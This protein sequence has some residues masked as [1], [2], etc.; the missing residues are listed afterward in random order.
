MKIDTRYGFVVTY[1]KSSD[2]GEKLLID[3]IKTL[4]KQNYYLILASHSADVPLEVQQLC[5]FYFYQEL[6]IVDDRKYSHGVAE[7]NLIEIALQHLK[8]KKIEWTY[9]VCYDVVIEDVSRFDDWIQDYNYS[10]VSCNWGHNF[11][12]T[13]SFFA[14]VNFILNNIDFYDS[15]EEM[16][17]ID[18]VLEN[19]WQ[20]NIEDKKLKHEVYSYADKQTFFSEYNKLD[21][22]AY[23]Y[24]D[25]TFTVDLEDKKFYITNSGPDFIGEFRIYDYYSDT[26]IYAESSVK[27]SSGITMWIVPPCVQYMSKAKN[28]FYLEMIP[29]DNNQIIRKNILIKDFSYKDPLHKKFKTFKRAEI[30]Y[31]EY[32]DFDEFYLY[33][34]I[35]INLDKIRNFVDI[36]ANLGFFSV[37]LIRKNIKTYMIDADTNNYNILKESYS[38]DKNI[39]IIGKAI[40]NVDGEVNFYIEEGG[41]SVVSSLFEVN[42]MGL[43]PPTRRKVTVPS[44]TPNTLIEEYV[45]EEYIDLMKVDIEGGEY[46]LFDS[47]SDDNMQKIS[48]FIIEI[49]NNEN[50]EILSI[51]QKLAKNGFYYKLHNWGDFTNSYIIENKMAVIHAW[52]Q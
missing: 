52:K 7:N 48:K 6:N 49:H 13:H 33:K 43:N 42:A 2:E 44:I 32:C 34:E 27:H 25:F 36:G 37:P 31:N 46:I 3:L 22:L 23:Q 26:C 1:F 12:C 19:C 24:H 45:D 16:F 4:S 50:Y 8:H 21:T 11:L 28:G 30:K 35:N 17:A 14:N 18:N 15:I 39:K 9:K 38:K 47:I 41:G 51:L 29:Q 20:K 10:F 5:D 40:S